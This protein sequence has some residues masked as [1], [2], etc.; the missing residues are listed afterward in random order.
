MCKE[1]LL[2]PIYVN[3]KKS[4][5]LER[6]CSVQQ[7]CYK[8]QTTSRPVKFPAIQALD[9]FVHLSI[10]RRKDY[11]EALC[12]FHNPSGHVSSAQVDFSRVAFE[13]VAPLVGSSGRK[14]RRLR[15]LLRRERRIVTT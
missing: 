2:F 5:V 9:L 12:M 15:S 6:H 7:N 14:F 8:K 10:T 3:I 13:I 1:F 4:S 11:S